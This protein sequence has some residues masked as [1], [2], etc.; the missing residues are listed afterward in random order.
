VCVLPPRFMSC[1]NVTMHHLCH[2]LSEHKCEISSLRQNQAESGHKGH[3][4]WPEVSFSNFYHHHPRLGSFDV[5]FMGTYQNKRLVA[6]PLICWRFCPPLMV[7]L[8]NFYGTGPVHLLISSHPV[9]P[10]NGL[11]LKAY[12][13]PSWWS[14]KPGSMWAWP[15][16]GETWPMQ[17]THTDEMPLAAVERAE[18]LAIELCPTV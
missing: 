4:L 1:I 7:K 8:M 9:F 12:F 2:L 13:P 10:R 15:V 18:G 6:A 17:L 11:W 5:L 3:N 16:V 14:F